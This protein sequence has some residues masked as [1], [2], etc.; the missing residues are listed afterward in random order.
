MQDLLSLR[1]EV[2][3]EVFQYS[4]PAKYKRIP[5]HVWLR[6][7]SDMKGL[8]VVRS[9]DCWNWY[10]RQLSETVVQR[11][12]QVE[13]SSI[14]KTLGYY[15]SNNV[16]QSIIE[17]RLIT[18]QPLQFTGSS[19]WFT[20]SIINELRFIEGFYH[21]VHGDL[22]KEA[23]NELTS[24]NVICGCAL[25]GQGFS[26]VKY[27]QLLLD[28]LNKEESFPNEIKERVRHYFRWLY[29]DMTFISRNPRSVIP[30]SSTSQPK[31]SIVRKDMI[32]LIPT[33]KIN[34]KSNLNSKAEQIFRGISLGGFSDFTPCMA[35]LLG[36]CY[37]WCC[38][39]V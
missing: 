20:N 22:L 31:S 24:F 5:L 9:F 33:C 21:L 27:I 34:N 10:H 32:K 14:H 26:I 25:V 29:Q 18:K 3:K 2:I 1:E 36:F 6:L 39:I 37:Y 11:Y 7:C 8:I 30:P 4:Q 35:T 23:I 19:I 28:K 13:I 12:S 15:F 16:S 17:E 38:L